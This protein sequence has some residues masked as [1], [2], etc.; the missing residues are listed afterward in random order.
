MNNAANI[1]LTIRE[2][3]SRA[4]VSEATLRR[5]IKARRL[6]ATRVGGRRSWRLRPEWVDAWLQEGVQPV[7][8][9][10]TRY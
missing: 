6:T 7:I 4:R 10:A 5:E 8:Q 2:A 9:P 3:A 1:W